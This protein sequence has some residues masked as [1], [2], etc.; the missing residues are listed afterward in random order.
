M[1]YYVE[2]YGCTLNQGETEMIADSYE[3]KGHERVY[4]PSEA[5]I[6]ILG[7]C[8]VIRKTEQRMKRRIDE[9]QDKCS[10]LVVTGCLTTTDREDVE[11]RCSKAQL[12]EPGKMDMTESYNRSNIGTIPISTGCFGNCT[13]CITKIARGNLNSRPLNEIKRRFRSC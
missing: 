1:K 8:V 5:D 6:A 9:L 12:I 7:T 2:S 13:Y 11:E 3:E 4:D 10:N